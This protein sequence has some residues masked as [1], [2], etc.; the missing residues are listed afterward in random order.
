MIPKCPFWILFGA[1]KIPKRY[2]KIPKRYKKDTKKQKKDTAEE[3]V[4]FLFEF[5]LFCPR[6]K[7]RDR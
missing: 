4:S 2:K 1:K 5:S 7:D 3:R 6:R